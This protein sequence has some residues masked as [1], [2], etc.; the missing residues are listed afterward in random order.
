MCKDNRYK[1]GFRVIPFL[2]PFAKCSNPGKLLPRPYLTFN[3]PAWV[4]LVRAYHYAHTLRNYAGIAMKP[5]TPA[6]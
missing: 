5:H 4:W 1:T 2:E 3:T 6:K